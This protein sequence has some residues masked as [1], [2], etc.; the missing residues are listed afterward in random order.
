M[1]AGSLAEQ[2]VSNGPA[3]E[4]P[5][6]SPPLSAGGP[7]QTS[8]SDQAVVTGQNHVDSSDVPKVAQT[9][10]EAAAQ[11]LWLP[12]PEV[13]G[14]LDWRWLATHESD[15]SLDRLSPTLNLRLDGRIVPSAAAGGARVSFSHLVVLDG[16]FGEPERQEL[17]GFLTGQSAASGEA[18][19]KNAA[20]IAADESADDRDGTVP[21]PR[22]ERAT[23]DRAGLPPT[24]GLKVN[25]R[26]ILAGLPHLLTCTVCPVPATVPKLF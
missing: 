21:G 7:Q 17:A 18:D 14:G 24:W 4:L 23:A 8:A 25:F 2:P 19:D 6:S 15:W 10:T 22:W 5:P 13:L 26:R 16:F 3:I 12:A 11:G 9:A 20:S 1:A